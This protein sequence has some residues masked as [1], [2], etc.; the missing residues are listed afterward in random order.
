MSNFLHGFTIIDTSINFSLLQSLSSNMCIYFIGIFRFIFQ[1]LLLM[2][3]LGM[4]FVMIKFCRYVTAIH[5]LCQYLFVRDCIFF[6]TVH[7][8]FGL[9]IKVRYS[10]KRL[11]M[12][13]LNPVSV[14]LQR[15]RIFL[16]LNVKITGFQYGILHFG[17]INTC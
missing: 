15:Q 17:N 1:L 8:T 13:E 3:F 14:P 7:V 11:I 5:C 12:L 6:M 2:E 16:C 9:V 10:A 4:A